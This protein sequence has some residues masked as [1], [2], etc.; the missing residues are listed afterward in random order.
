MFVKKHCDCGCDMKLGWANRKIAQQ[1]AAL[2]EQVHYLKAVPL[3]II[4][5]A[6]SFEEASDFRR[7]IQDGTR[8]YEP[9]PVHD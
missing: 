5:Q 1:S 8:R 9:G 4:T 3:Q 7:F 6:T 2:Q